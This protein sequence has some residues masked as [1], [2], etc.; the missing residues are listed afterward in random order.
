[1]TPE[2]S[3]LFNGRAS[4][5][6][7]LD[8]PHRD[9]R[10]QPPSTNGQLR[11]GSHQ[12]VL[13]FALCS[14]HLRLIRGEV[15]ESLPI[16]AHP[17]LELLDLGHDRNV[18]HDLSAIAAVLDEVHRGTFLEGILLEGPAVEIQVR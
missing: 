3:L 7:P 10:L 5:L 16:M 17:L 18:G 8:S 12:V 13:R 9:Q 15:T 14:G 11:L 6:L 1:M 4:Q 2:R